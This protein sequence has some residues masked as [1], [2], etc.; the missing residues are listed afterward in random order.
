MEHARHETRHR[1]DT[2]EERKPSRWNRVFEWKLRSRQGTLLFVAVLL[3]PALLLILETGRVVLAQTLG[4]S[5]NVQSIRHAMAIDPAN[6][7]PHFELGKILLLTG[8]PAQQVVAEEQ[9]R[10]AIAMNRNSAVYWSSLAAAC[11]ALA[12]Q[13]CAD[14]GF[15]RA[16]ELA[17]SNPIFAW[18]SA[19]ND[20][21]SNQP[22]AAVRNLKAFL[23]LQPEGL[24]QSFQL[25]TRGFDNPD[26]VWHDLLGSPADTNTQIK[27]LEFLAA[28]DRVDAADGFWRDLAAQKRTVSIAQVTPYIDQLLANGHYTEAANVWSY[29]RAQR[30]TNYADALSD[31][32]LVFNGSFEHEPL[33]AGFD[34]R[35]AQQPY[36]DLSFS[37]PTARSGKKALEV[38]FTVPQNA[39]YDLLYQFVPVEPNQTYEL[40]AF[41]KVQGVTSDSGARLRV[42]DPRCQA[43]LDVATD[44]P[45]GTT[46][47]RRVD[48]QFS[49][50]PATDMIR[51]SLWR[52]RSRSYPTEITG[53]LWLD[54]VS[55]V[56]AGKQ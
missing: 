26:L 42:L 40:S 8:D 3:V 12:N 45:T 38:D 19:V 52:P 37:N 32:N 36:V 6:P 34:W 28:A 17:P 7:D 18:Q 50:G 31:P 15:A 1:Q 41:F 35:H 51:L 49:T 55:L 53:Q 23:R 44:G 24:A 20:V 30:A 14:D 22:Q 25:L 47:W 54:D 5:F 16:Q 9:F 48:K 27:F 29:A 46:D 39:E 56:R 10:T 21:V 33:N 11:Y 2:E 13:A 4:D 43:C